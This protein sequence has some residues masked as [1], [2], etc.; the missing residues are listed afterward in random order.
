MKI[1][2]LVKS[3]F[4]KNYSIKKLIIISI[5]LLI[6]SVALVELNN[7]LHY[8]LEDNTTGTKEFM[9]QAKRMYESE[10]TSSDELSALR[11]E[12][13]KNRYE[14]YSK[15]VDMDVSFRSWQTSLTERTLDLMYQNNAITYLNK[16]RNSE[17]VKGLCNY[18]ADYYDYVMGTIHHYCNAFTQEELDELFKENEKLIKDYKEIINE[19]KYYLYLKYQLDNNIAPST[20][21]KLSDT[22][23]NN[24]I[25]DG[26]DFRIKNF[27]QD[28]YIDRFINYELLSEEEFK[29][30]KDG[31]LYEESRIYSNY[32]QYKKYYKLLKE[33]AIKDKKI[34][35]YSSV[36]NIK[37]DLSF[38]DKMLSQITDRYL[39]PTA[40]TS[41]NLILHLSVIVLILVA[42]TSGGIVSK[43]HN[44]GTIK[45]IIT[46]PV[47]RYKILLSKFIY[48]ILHTYIIWFIGLILLSIY[49]GIKFGFDDL[50][51]PKLIYSSGKV[52]EVNYYLYVIKDMLI[53]GIPIICFLSI[54][55][56]LSTIS[57]NTALTI[58]VTTILSFISPILYVYSEIAPTAFVTNIPFLYFD[59]GFILL[60]SKYYTGLLK[61]TDFGIGKAVIVSLVTTLIL[62]TITNIVYSRRDIKN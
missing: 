29:H 51:T 17:Y 5:I 15:L 20:N 18:D 53:A 24:K 42:V 60:N 50:F 8:D 41:V 37:H 7:F 45:N 16:N 2:N 39:Y 26:N 61:I 35:E 32:N 47:K 36:N 59:S 10:L 23:I 6:S 22:I 21:I 43:E 57:L 48:L 30:G 55:L 3:E 34:I 40:K 27:I 62:Y 58:S 52:I 54:L 19:G 25:I 1:I 9:Y 46:A 4:I 56:F 31:A 49:S 38:N 28:S 14:L 11:Q 33:E 12:K 13:Y 44:T